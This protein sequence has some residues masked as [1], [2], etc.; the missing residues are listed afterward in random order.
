M[1][2]LLLTLIVSFAMCGS[3]FAQYESHWPD[4]Y[5]PAFTDQLPV[6]AAIVIDDE[7]VTADNHPDN[8]NALEIAFFVGDECR[9][10]GVE[11]GDYQAFVNYLYNGYV[12]EYGDPFPILDGTP[13][14]FN[15]TSA[16]EVVTVKMYDHVNGIEYN[17]CIVTRFGEPYT[18]LTGAENDQGWFDTENP[19]MLNFTSPTPETHYWDEDDTWSQGVPGE[20]VNVTLETNVT[21]R[22]NDT[23]YADTV[24][25]NGFTLTMEPGAQFYHANGVELTIQMEVE[26]Y[27]ETRGESNAGYRLIASPVYALNSAPAGIPVPAVMVPT[28]EPGVNIFDLYWF[29]QTED[30]AWRNYQ[31][32]EFTTLDL[33]KGYLYANVANV[34]VSF[35]GMT[36]PTSVDVSE[37]LVYEPGHAFTGWNLLGN[38]YT[39]KAY[40]DRPFYV[41]DSIGGSVDVDP[42][43]GAAIAPM[44]GFF[45]LA[46]GANETCLFSTTPQNNNGSLTL[47]LSKSCVRGAVDRAIVAF[48]GNSNLAK[49]QFNPNR[50]KVYIPQDGTDYAVVSAP[51]MGEMPVN[52]K[53][54]TNGSYTMSFGSENVTFSYLHLIDNLTGADVD[55]L[56]TPS[57]TFDATTTD[58]ASRFRLVFATSGNNDGDSF[59]FFSNGSFVVSNEGEAT[60]QVVDV[61]G[62]ILKSENI[63]GSASVKVNAA[64]GVYMLRLVN[65]NDVKVQKVVVE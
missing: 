44:E 14:Y 41:L 37:D 51:E 5:Y 50:T 59:A 18:I 20:Y 62:R 47:S 10:A 46:E 30:S 21:I 15:N 39:A 42:Q 31:A 36:L 34:F 55:L 60:L 45:V 61:M 38:P 24:N 13:L 27:D 9:G 64:S 65:G 48:G 8:W 4:F 12:E 33:K 28:E 53:A 25:L 26:G 1:K 7:I 52:F 43:Y 35:A 32:E 29:D 56:A 40:I 57:Y 63:S 2:K 54:E 19:I 17:E 16:G 22:A 6:V 3:I 58:Y 11:F 49:F 23:V